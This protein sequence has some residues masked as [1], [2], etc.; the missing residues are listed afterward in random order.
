MEG[1]SKH[2]ILR[3]SSFFKTPRFIH[4]G[5]CG[6]TLRS[7]WKHAGCC[8]RIADVSKTRCAWSGS[9]AS[10]MPTRTSFPVAWRNARLWRAL[11]NDPKLLILDEP[12]GQLD[13]LTRIMMQG[14]LVSLWQRAGFTALLVTHDV[15]EALFLAGRV[16]VLSQRPAHIKA[17]IINSRPYPRHRGDAHL[18]ELR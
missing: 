3:A 1:R 12:L 8:V 9:Q 11:V 16:V 14:E 5:R 4:G 10:P 17:E 15:E 18:V 6:A 7:D 13:S 2:P